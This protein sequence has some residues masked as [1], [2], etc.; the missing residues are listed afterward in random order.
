MN[1]LSHIHFVPELNLASL[2]ISNMYTNIPTKD[3]IGIIDTLCRKHNLEDKLI[4]EILTINRL[5]I[6]QNYFSFQ[7]RT[8]LQG[9]GMAK[10][11][12]TSSILSEIYLQFLENTQIFD[13]LKEE[14]IEGYFGYMDDILIIYNENI[15]DIEHVLSLFNDITLSLNFTLER[16]Q[17]NKLNFLDLKIIKTTD[18]ISFD[19]YRKPTTPDIIIPN[20][21]CHRTEQKL[22][23]IRY[24]TNRINTYDLDYTRKQKQIQ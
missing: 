23:A 15:T 19:I 11:A 22:A 13:I 16:K 14:R 6:M 3:L 24:F 4:R 20:D 12:P 9:N 2:D 8:Y 21:S 17:E 18:K 5:I 1:D 10:G 7:D